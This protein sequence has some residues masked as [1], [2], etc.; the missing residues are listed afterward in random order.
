MVG[1]FG[2]ARNDDG[3]QVVGGVARQCRWWCFDVGEGPGHWCATVERLP[4]GDEFVAEHAEGV[5]V[6]LCGDQLAECLFGTDVVGGAPD[7]TGHSLGRAVEVLGDAEVHELGYSVGGDEHVGRLE[8]AVDNPVLVCPFQR[9]GQLDEQ[10]ATSSDGSVPQSV[11][12]SASDG[13]SMN[14]IT[15]NCR[16]SSSPKSKTST[17]LGGLSCAANRAS[18]RNR[19]PRANR[20]R[21]WGSV[22]LRATAAP[23]QCR[24]R[25][26]RGPCRPLQRGGPADS[27]IPARIRAR[28]GS[29]AN[30]LTGTR[31][32]GTLD[33]PV[34]T[35]VDNEYGRR[36]ASV[37]RVL[38][39]PGHGSPS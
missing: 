27:A 32:S 18:A 38:L 35:D 19:R 39:R 23:A 29:S 26:T 5:Q 8:V 7:L 12:I 33:R 15:K 24:F 6:A 17:M 34:H 14:S 3:T 1:V 4:S 11:S 2:Q 21:L 25:P 31:T 36:L 13:P 37:W 20:S 30:L 22:T 9:A 28:A 16:P 10:R